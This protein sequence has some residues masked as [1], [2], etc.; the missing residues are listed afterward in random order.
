LQQHQ[1]H[2]V[3]TLRDFTQHPFEALLRSGAACHLLFKR[4]GR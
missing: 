4:T 3:L 2:V 1:P